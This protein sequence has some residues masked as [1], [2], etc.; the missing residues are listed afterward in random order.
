M[1]KIIWLKWEEGRIVPEETAWSNEGAERSCS[2]NWSFA[3]MWGMQE[4]E[5]RLG[6]YKWQFGVDFVNTG[7]E[8]FEQF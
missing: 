3:G 5:A 4:G 8:G 1:K 7:E 2:K 6:N